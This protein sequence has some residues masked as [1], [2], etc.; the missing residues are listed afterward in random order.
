MRVLHPP[1]G[2]GFMKKQ[3]L[4][5]DGFIQMSLQ[6]AY[7]RLHQHVPKTYEPSTHRSTPAL[8]EF[9]LYL[10]DVILAYPFVCTHREPTIL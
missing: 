5:P 1:Y 8:L 10:A 6:L 9:V 3:R 4:S 2:K 7:Y